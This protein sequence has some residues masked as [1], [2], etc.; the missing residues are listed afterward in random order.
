M[1]GTIHVV[2]GGLAVYGGTIVLSGAA[3]ISD[4]TGLFKRERTG[5]LTEGASAADNPI[6]PETRSS[7]T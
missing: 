2:G 7:N 6:P 3:K 1:T 4:V 5:G